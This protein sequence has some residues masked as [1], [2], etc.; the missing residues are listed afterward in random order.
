[1]SIGQSVMSGGCPDRADSRREGVVM[2]DRSAT[3]FARA[4]KRHRLAAGVG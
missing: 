2:G 3:G 1:M 4:A